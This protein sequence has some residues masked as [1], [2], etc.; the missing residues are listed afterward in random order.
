MRCTVQEGYVHGCEQWCSLQQHATIQDRPG[1]L[2]VHRCLVCCNHSPCHSLHF[3]LTDSLSLPLS[4]HHTSSPFSSSLPS[5]H[6]SSLPSLLHS[7]SSLL[8]HSP[9]LTTFL[10]TPS[11][12]PLPSPPSHHFTFPPSLHHSLPFSPSIPL[13]PLSS[14]PLHTYIRTCTCI[15]YT[16]PTHS[17][18]M[19]IRRYG[20]MYT[21][22]HVQ[23]QMFTD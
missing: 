7:S 5:L 21:H 19:Y 8:H 17:V 15:H 4:H 1:L 22:V 9:I 16:P 10:A 13:P 2:C 20:Y 11:F 14:P 3:V 18:H 23:P 12:I 6:L